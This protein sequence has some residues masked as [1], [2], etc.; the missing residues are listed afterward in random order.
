[1]RGGYFKNFLW[2][3]LITLIRILQHQSGLAF[4]LLRVALRV[5]RVAFATPFKSSSDL[6][7]GDFSNPNSAC[8]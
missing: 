6:C 3:T 1:M 7:S 4:D 2:L 8:R 5:I